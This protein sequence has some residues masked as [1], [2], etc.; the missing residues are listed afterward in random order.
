MHVDMVNR[1]YFKIKILEEEV[2]E[3]IEV[4]DRRLRRSLV[5]KQMVALGGGK[6][7]ASTPPQILEFHE[8]LATCLR[9][10]IRLVESS[11]A[12]SGAC[13]KRREG[14]EF[15]A[16]ERVKFETLVE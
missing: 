14:V 6:C 5:E 8:E 11:R 10:S 2:K 12:I 7:E 1:T 16:D 4:S 15:E 3:M 13:V 9:K